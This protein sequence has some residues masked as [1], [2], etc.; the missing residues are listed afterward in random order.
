MG[1]WEIISLQFSAD[2]GL[3]AVFTRRQSLGFISEALVADEWKIGV[4][5]ETVEVMLWSYEIQAEEIPEISP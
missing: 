1:E 5:I 4:Q 2:N 3:F